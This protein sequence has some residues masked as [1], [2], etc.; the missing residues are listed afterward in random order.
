MI[1]NHAILR[2]ATAILCI[3]MTVSHVF[4]EN[5]EKTQKKALE[6]QA[7][8]IISEAKAL[9]S[10]GRLAEARAK[11]A[12]S[13]AL[14][15]TNEAA[16]AIKHLDGEIK[17]L[18]EDLLNKSRKLYEAHK[19]HESIALLDTGSKLGAL[20]A[21]FY[22]D[23]ALCHYQLG[24][25]DK[26]VEN[27]NQAVRGTPDP[28]KK[29]KLKQWVTFF[30][31]KE[32]RDAASDK[33]R[34][35]NV[36]HLVETVGLDISLEDDEGGEETPPFADADPAPNVA[37]VALKTSASSTVRSHTVLGKRASLCAA[38]ETLKESLSSSA[39]ITFDRANCAES[40]QRPNEAVQLFQKYLDL[41]PDALDAPQVRT[42]IAE[43]QAELT[44]PAPAGTEVRRLYAS[45]YV[46]LAEGKYDRALAAFNKSKELA[47]D[48]DLTYWKL[49]LLHE[50]SGNV[51]LARENFQH[52]QQLT[53]EQAAKDEAALHLSI[54]DAK[55][56]KYD[57]EVDDAEDILADL[58][59]RGMNLTFNFDEKR[60][61]IR[62]RRAQIKKK[63]DRKKDQNRVGG[64]SVP[65]PY[66]QQQLAQASEHLNI[67]LALFPLAPE[68]NELMG[69]VFLQA[70][71]GG[72]A[73]R[74]FDVV[75]S[76]DLPVSFFAEM[77]GGHRFDHAVKCE[78][79][80][81]RIRFIFLSSYDK[82][83]Q[84][85]P[86]DQNAGDDG[87]GDLTLSP[88]DKR[89]PFD[90]LDLSINDIKKVETN[91]GVMTIKLAKEQF[92]VA[93]IYLPSF[94]PV[95]GPPA[96]RFANNYT[97]LFIR[98]PGLEDSK[99]GAEGMTG[100]EKFVMGYRLATAGFNI[101]TSLNPVGA[102]TATQNAIAIARI[103]H[104]AMSS[105]T[106]SFASWEKSVDDQ[107]QLLA[108][109]AFKTIPTESV[110]LAFVQELK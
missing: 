55:K 45:A 80:H 22:Y 18:A 3:A 15:E 84:S 94:T 26:A 104:S 92:T 30:T 10:S 21:T 12:E 49:A 44:V 16:D 37:P 85:T 64:F 87:L 83:G 35:E 77:R 23:L 59:N 47:P 69:L 96:R 56:S 32:N 48:F 27:V 17:D 41:S 14:I 19:Y 31:T 38:L 73:T 8:E 9:A 46:D 25:R 36:N 28:K 33:D 71:D 62:A 4:A 101:A 6:T 70:N 50:A 60:S 93:P 40:N 102:I 43:L 61:A 105:L 42:R 100:A 2:L 98:Y 72:A 107:Q 82:K 7:K 34:I 67:A 54:L 39:A 109:Q 81:D 90:S 76:Q 99:L 11:Y 58:F 51:D 13:Q 97:R 1:A 5:V 95:E 65:Y 66:A 91:R 20:E 29:Q 108:N 110:N 63:K 79:T 74:S 68:A 24:E 57:D 106:V 52:Y 103:I 89:E 75:A 86:P 88:G 78:L 53:S